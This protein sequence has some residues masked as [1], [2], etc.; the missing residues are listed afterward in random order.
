MGVCQV[1]DDL[2]R[3]FIYIERHFNCMMFSSLEIALS[4]LTMSVL[5]SVGLSNTDIIFVMAVSINLLR[6]RRMLTSHK[7]CIVMVTVGLE[8]FHI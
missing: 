4:H 3:W 8:N 7:V 5:K 6:L 2:G 1:S